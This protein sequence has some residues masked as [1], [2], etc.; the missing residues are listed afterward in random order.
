MIHFLTPRLLLEALAT[1]S[2][3]QITEALASFVTLV[4]SGRLPDEVR[5]VMCAARLIALAKRDGGTRPIAVGDVL[6]RLAARCLVRRHQQLVVDATLLPTQVGVGV[7]SAPELVALSASA[8]ASCPPAGEGLLSI[9]FANAFNSVDRSA[10]LSSVYSCAPAFAQYARLCYG[11]PSPLVGKGFVLSSSQGTQQG[12]ACGPL[13]FSLAIQPLV[14]ALA[15]HLK[16]SRWYLDD[17]LLCGDQRS[18][19]AAFSLLLDRSSALGLSPRLPKCKLWAPFLPPPISPLAGVSCLS[20]LDGG[21]V[22][23]GC[24]VG[25]PVF[26]RDG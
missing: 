23:L 15:P 11:A 10:M 22:V 3:P 7:P 2:G 25:S 1:S 6:R 5:P 16:W 26:V 14:L 8:W 12:D 13:F 17:G 9:D 18:L 21:L 19:E 24:P 20:W 4:A